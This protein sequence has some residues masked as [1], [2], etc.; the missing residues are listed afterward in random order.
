MAF[1]I[2][3]GTSSIGGQ[4]QKNRHRN[5]YHHE[6]ERTRDA[7]QLRLSVQFRRSF[8]STKRLCGRLKVA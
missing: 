7:V 6:A 8:L 5:N 3:H 1:V 4:R 2:A